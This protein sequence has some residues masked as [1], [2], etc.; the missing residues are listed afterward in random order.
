MGSKTV[1]AGFFV[2]DSFSFRFFMFFLVNFIR[3]ALTT[4]TNKLKRK[5][6]NVG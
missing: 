2:F 1:K 4:L 5:Q 6:K 3:F